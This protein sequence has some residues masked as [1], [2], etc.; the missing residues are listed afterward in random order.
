MT[1][2]VI[3]NMVDR[4]EEMSHSAVEVLG[5]VMMRV[6]DDDV[7]LQAEI[8]SLYQLL[9]SVRELSD[10]LFDTVQELTGGE[11]KIE[12]GWT[13]DRYVRIAEKWES[14]QK[15]REEYAEI[16]EL[17]LRFLGVTSDEYKERTALEPIQHE[18]RE[19]RRKLER[20]GALDPTD[21]Y[22]VRSKMETVRFFF[23]AC[24][25]DDK[26]QLREA[27]RH[28][29]EELG[30]DA[31]FGVLIHSY[32]LPESGTEKAEVSQPAETAEGKRGLAP[33]EPEAH[34]MVAVDREPSNS[35][36][37][38]AVSESAGAKH[39]T[40]KTDGADAQSEFWMSLGL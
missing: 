19:M 13:V 15:S 35:G 4:Y 39:L 21:S 27:V 20:T 8:D 9:N 40:P 24:E 1:T 16:M 32:I 37:E 29:K 2:D 10:Q 33:A 5:D 31:A 38:S 11:E 34:H 6:A 22:R 26:E 36:T 28:V 7:P 3:R 23:Q 30:E 25:A 17:F 18:I 12:R 14:Q